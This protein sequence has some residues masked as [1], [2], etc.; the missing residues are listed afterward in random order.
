MEAAIFVMMEI[1]GDWAG[2]AGGPRM[3]DEEDTCVI[4]LSRLEARGGGG[5]RNHY[6]CHD[7]MVSPTRLGRVRKWGLRLD[8]ACATMKTLA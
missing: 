3:R 8:P 4:N 5:C 7:N 1:P 2:S 6:F